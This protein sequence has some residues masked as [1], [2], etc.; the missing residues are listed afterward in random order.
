MSFLKKSGRAA[1]ITGRVINGVVTLGGSE[2]LR[3]AKALYDSE[4]TAY[5]SLFNE[6]SE[7]KQQMDHTLERIGEDVAAAQEA[8]SA[9]QKILSSQHLSLEQKTLS[10]A[11]VEKLAAFNTSFNSAMTAGFGGVVGGGA[12]VGAWAVVSLVGSA[13]TGT[14]LSTLSGA[15]AY[16]ATLAWFGGG[17]LAAGGAGMSGGMMVLG[18]IVAA[19]I[20]FFAAKG[21]Y[22]KA[23]K[24]REESEKLK[25]EIIKLTDVK[26]K[27]Q[28]QLDAV[29]RYHGIIQT[30]SSDYT[31]Q[32]YE[33]IKRLY[34][35]GVLSRLKQR[36][37]KVFG[38]AYFSETQ[39]SAFKELRSITDRFL[40]TFAVQALDI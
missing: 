4:Q 14:A 1:A 9:C 16:N 11:T 24:T 26:K 33:L 36:V 6:V 40:E 25:S 20:I 23:K 32:S 29:T 8:L 15:A 31:Q 30:L 28:E 3:G 18:G 39:L 19:P 37:L 21:A 27:T 2:E 12:A 22:A 17:A 35:Y 10:A 38:A 13:S 5:I 34:P 7:L